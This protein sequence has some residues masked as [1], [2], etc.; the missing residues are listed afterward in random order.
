MAKHLPP[1]AAALRLVDI[2]GRAGAVFARAVSGHPVEALALHEDRDP[3]AHL[4]L[5]GLAQ[6]EDWETLAAVSLAFH[7]RM[8]FTALDER[9]TDY[10]SRV[11]MME[12]ML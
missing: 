3:A 2:G 1:S 9:E 6:V 11:V 12:K 7:D 10:G 4:I 5:D 8:G